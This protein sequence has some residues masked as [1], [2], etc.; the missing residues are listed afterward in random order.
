LCW[1]DREGEADR[2]F[3]SVFGVPSKRQ[4]FH[5]GPLPDNVI[6][7]YNDDYYANTVKGRSNGRE[8]MCARTKVLRTIRKQVYEPR[9]EGV[10]DPYNSARDTHCMWSSL[11]RVDSSHWA[12]YAALMP[13]ETKLPVIADDEYRLDRAGNVIARAAAKNTIFSWDIDHYFPWALG[14]CTEP[15]NLHLLQSSANRSKGNTLWHTFQT[16]QFAGLQRGLTSNEF[17]QLLVTR[18]LYGWSY[19]VWVSANMGRAVKHLIKKREQVMV[20][21]QVA[22]KRRCRRE[23]SMETSS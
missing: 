11:A 12:H 15:N 22:P 13:D 7:T 21:R 4:R 18:T 2:S 19:D 17:C 8:T 9:A 23:P 14:G 1:F 3:P 16:G 6:Q 10:P 5:V 20:V